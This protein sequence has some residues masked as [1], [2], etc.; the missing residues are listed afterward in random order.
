MK[1]YLKTDLRSSKLKLV[2]YCETLHKSLPFLPLNF[3]FKR[4]KWHFISS[5]SSTIYLFGRACTIPDNG[6]HCV[7]AS[8]ME[9]NWS[10]RIVNAENTSTMAIFKL[11]R[12]SLQDKIG[13]VLLQKREQH[14]HFKRRTET[15]LAPE[16]RWYSAWLS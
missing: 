14:Y 15:A 10:H 2:Q 7:S 8:A 1:T 5:H 4:W 13:S 9:T 12:L 3:P 6:L 16:Q 11:L